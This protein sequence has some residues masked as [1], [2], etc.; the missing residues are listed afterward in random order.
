ML[1]GIHGFSEKGE[2]EQILWL[3]DIS[4]SWDFIPPHTCTTSVVLLLYLSEFFSSSVLP[5]ISSE[6]FQGQMVKDMMNMVGFQVPE[7][8][9]ACLSDSPTE[10]G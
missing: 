3:L 6:I 9:S 7:K 5:N 2:G 1:K 4:W 10:Y 8:M